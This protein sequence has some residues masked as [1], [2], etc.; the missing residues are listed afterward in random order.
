MKDFCEFHG[1]VLF[2]AIRNRTQYPPGRINSAV[3]NELR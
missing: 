3:A 1:A 2:L